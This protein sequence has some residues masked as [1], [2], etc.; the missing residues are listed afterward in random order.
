MSAIGPD[1]IALQ[2]RDLE[3]SASFYADH[4]GLTRAP[5]SPDHAIV[6]ATL[7]IPFAL[8]EPL[9]DLDAVEHLG[10]GVAIWLKADDPQA[11]HDAMASAE[12]RIVVDPFDGP[13]GRTFAFADPDGYTVTIHS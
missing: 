4:L 8:R 9:I 11:L 10:W 6:F 7:P 13:F 2:V 3:V 5:V 1:F 12:V